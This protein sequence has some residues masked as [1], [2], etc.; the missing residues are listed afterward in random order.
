VLCDL[1]ERSLDEAARHLGWPLGT[2][3]SR[4]N[5]GRQQLRDRLVRRGVAPGVAGLALSG[6]ALVSPAEAAPAVSPALVDATAQMLAGAGK[7][8]TAVLVLVKGVGRMMIMT[9]MKIAA[10][11]AIALGLSAVGIGALA[12]G[13]RH[14]NGSNAATPQV[15][16]TTPASQKTAVAPAKRR[17]RPRDDS[18]REAITV[19]G[20]ATDPTGR[21]VAGA[22]VYVIDANRRLFGDGHDVLATAT[23]DPGGRFIAR[24][25]DLP[26]W[27][28]EPG[29]LPA[30]EEGR[31]QVAAT[32]PGFGFTW[33]PVA[34]FRP[35]ER[36]QAAPRTAPPANE[37]EAFYRGEAVAID[38]SFGPSATVHGKV[39]DDRGRP[40]ANVKV[41]VGVCNAG[42]RGQRMWTCRRV[43]PADPAPDERREFNGIH[44]L[45][46]SLLST[47]T[48]P[49]GSYRIDGLPR[50][51]Q[52][53]ARI[54]PGPDYE[55]F[56]DMI[57]TS[58]ARIANVRCLGH[59]AVL[60]WKSMAAR[61][62]PIVVRLADTKQPARNATV[63]ARSDLTTVGAGGV[64]VTDDEGRTMLHL[65]PGAYEI[66]VEPPFGAPYLPGQV[67]IPVTSD[68]DFH[69]YSPFEVEPA[70]IVTMEA[71]DAKTG[72]GIEG[73][74][75]RYETDA[76]S[77]RRELRSQLVVVDHPETDERGR[78]RAIVEPG[79]KR[80]FAGNVPPGWE[81]EGSPGRP[82]ILVAGRETTIRWSFT[83]VGEPKA[84]AASGPAQFPDDLVEKWRHQQSHVLPG[85]FRIRRYSYYVGDNPV[86]ADELEAFLDANDLGKVPDPAAALEARFPQ[87]PETRPIFYEITDDG[88][89]R[90]NVYGFSA[91]TR[92]DNVLVNNGYEVVRYDGSNGQSD[93]GYPFA[94]FGLRDVCVWPRVSPDGRL[95]GLATGQ[96]RREESGGRLTVELTS[97]DHTGRWVVDRKTGFLLADSTRWTR[98]GV[99]GNI[100]RQYGPKTYRDGVVLPTVCVRASFVDVKMHLIELTSIDEADLD[101]R[102]TPLDF[103]VAAPAET[104]IVDYREDRSHP[105]QGHNRYPVA[106]VLM[107]ADGM[108]SRNRSIEPVLKAG[109]PAPAL[110]P[111]SWLDRNGP[112]RP[113]EAAGKVVLVDFWGISCGPCVAE[114]PEVQAAADHFAEKR[115]DLVVIGVHESGASAEQVAEFARKRGLTYRLAVD[116]PAGEDGWFGATFK[117]YGVRAIPAAA[118]IDREGKV[119]F[120][121][122][123]REAL[124]EAAKLLGP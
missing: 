61:R 92:R 120:V 44:A 1:E 50:E 48:G 77:R 123:F 5:R 124:Q 108:S 74:R 66:A 117:D 93:I 46:E 105:K 71:R 27:K 110:R 11:V 35:G 14:G 47:R 79:R 63:R 70:A 26:V 112:S 55:P 87:M 20:R 45:P 57:A 22:T 73:V 9:R 101:Y 60:D 31:F 16:A 99:S 75:F 102:P 49:D 82:V 41:Q 118:V 8:P 24:D 116:R 43:D 34:C 40:L 115:Q 6:S 4:L 32:A 121:G 100:L 59:D 37:P 7:P 23:T 113:P 62:V 89:R 78:L 122:R 103:T 17:T 3:K 21:P 13:L 81:L 65:K 91:E 53:L 95:P 90:R 19:A 52:L 42:R 36:P 69:E 29:L 88:R 25:V 58:A 104:V 85:K 111:A 56:E 10:V 97:A 68:A 67:Q 54:D 119:A 96:V 109:Q 18:R 94:V 33:H 80:F 15:V 12:G 30:P 107:Y 51:A 84:D 64:G 28:P 98:R 38:L 2:I 76:D 83:Q 106:D 86:A 114:L 39:V 72:A